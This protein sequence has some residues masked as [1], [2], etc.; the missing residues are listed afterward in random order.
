MYLRFKQKNKTI[1]I[2]VSGEIDHHTSKE[3]RRQ[4][5]SAMSE[6]GGRNLVFDF[7]NVSFMDSSG[8]GML[9]GRYKQL[10]SMQ[11][12]I[13]IICT[14]EKIVEII[15]LSGLTKLFPIFDSLEDAL[16][17]AEGRERNAV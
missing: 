11:G 6:M 9:I 5:E 13:A 8:I 16:S 1:L 14:E 10:Q 7:T 4:T 12:R 2:M 17:Y 15:R 3:L